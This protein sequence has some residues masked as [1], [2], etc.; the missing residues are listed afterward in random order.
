MSESSFLS[1]ASPHCVEIQVKSGKA[2]SSLASQKQGEA[3][4]MYSNIPSMPLPHFIK[5]NL[6][7]QM[8]KIFHLIISPRLVI[9][10]A[11]VHT[12]WSF[13]QPEGKL[14]SVCPW[15]SVTPIINNH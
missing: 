9:T 10:K 8:S 6:K 4:G 5:T 1:Q 2:T 3:S 15:F 11:F 14:G 7:Q 12:H 13:L